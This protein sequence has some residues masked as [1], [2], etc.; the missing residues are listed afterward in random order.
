[1][2]VITIGPSLTI[3]FISNTSSDEINPIM[4]SSSPLVDA[5]QINMVNVILLAQTALTT[6]EID[7]QNEEI[8]LI[9]SDRRW[10]KYTLFFHI[11]LFIYNLISFWIKGDH[12]PQKFSFLLFHSRFQK[13]TSFFKQGFWKKDLLCIAIAC[14]WVWSAKTYKL[15]IKQSARLTHIYWIER[16]YPIVKYSLLLIVLGIAFFSQDVIIE[17]CFLLLLIL[18]AVSSTK[19]DKSK[20]NGSEDDSKMIGQLKWSLFVII[21]LSQMMKVEE[22]QTILPDSKSKQYSHI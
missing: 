14:L 12:L 13:D 10:A 21:L 22:F 9:A 4:A 7:S 18:L 11:I 1:M 2:L 19:L 17:L 5:L 6:P 15:V 16:I 3:Y 8:R 20:T